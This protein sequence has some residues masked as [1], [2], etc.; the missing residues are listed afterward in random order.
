[1]FECRLAQGSLLRKIMEA[2]G[3]LVTEVNIECSSSGNLA[4][5]SEVAT[6]DRAE[7]IHFLFV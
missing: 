5:H 1:M 6:K 4:S 3:P 7:L 2:I